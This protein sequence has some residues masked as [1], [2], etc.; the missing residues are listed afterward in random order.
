[1]KNALAGLHGHSMLGGWSRWR[2]YVNAQ[3]ADAKRMR[4]G[5]SALSPDGRATRSAF[6]TWTALAEQQQVVR[7]A[8]IALT[9]RSEVSMLRVWAEAAKARLE[10][11]T[12]FRRLLN[13]MLHRDLRKSLNQW[14]D[15]VSD[16]SAAERRMRV[17]MSCLH[18]DGV[19]Q[20]WNTWVLYAHE[21]SEAM[22]RLRV[23]VTSL[24]GSKLTQAWRG[25]WHQTL[26]M[27]HKTQ[28]TRRMALYRCAQ[29]VRSWYT[30]SLEWSRMRSIAMSFSHEGQSKRHAISVWRDLMEERAL[31]HSVAMTLKRKGERAAFNAWQDMRTEQKHEKRIL[32]RSINSMRYNGLI[33]AYRSWVDYVV[34]AMEAQT[35]IYVALNGFS[36]H[37]MRQAWSTWSEAAAQGVLMAQRMR[38][39][40]QKRL[41]DG[42]TPMA[43]SCKGGKEE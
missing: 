40:V 37:G 23:V 1:M 15:Y 42:G 12:V 43:G 16:A 41:C 5:L 14:S 10:A 18:G 29:A 26:L 32:M 34:A 21:A 4:R 27:Q 20:G 31:M 13:A 38:R 17:A 33:A 24:Q 19:I 7:S 25:W 30:A 8:M 9:R 22:R 3:A 11:L 6:N 36:G 28:I 2:L 35:R 39:V